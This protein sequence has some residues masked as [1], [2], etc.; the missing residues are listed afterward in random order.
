M[1]C[2]L[3]VSTKKGT[4]GCRGGFHDIFKTYLTKYELKNSIS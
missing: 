3:V 4:W 1:D 2:D